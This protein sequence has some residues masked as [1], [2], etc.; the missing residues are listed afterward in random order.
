MLYFDYE[1]VPSEHIIASFRKG[2]KKGD[3]LIGGFCEWRNVSILIS[4]NRHF[5]RE[6]VAITS[7]KVMSPS[8]FCQTFDI[9]IT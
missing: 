2:L 5:L 4:D 8:E 1:P 7:F 3:A 9:S 6:L